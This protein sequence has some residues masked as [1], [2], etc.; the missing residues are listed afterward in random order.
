MSRND[1][2]RLHFVRSFASVLRPRSLLVRPTQSVRSVA[3]ASTKIQDLSAYKRK[4]NEHGRLFAE[5]VAKSEYVRPGDISALSREGLTFLDSD[6]GEM[7]QQLE[8]AIR[9]GSTSKLSDDHCTLL[10][11]LVYPTL[12]KYHSNVK[13]SQA[14]YSYFPAEADS[15]SRAIAGSSTKTPTET[16]PPSSAGRDHPGSATHEVNQ[17]VVEYVADRDADLVRT[18]TSSK[19]LAR[20]FRRMALE[21]HWGL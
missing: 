12:Q 13:L 14:E 20:E 15:A 3:K 8:A 1:K 18:M 9:S 21:L 5:I 17:I 4:L 11:E 19:I 6:L 16:P 2:V 7:V 10:V